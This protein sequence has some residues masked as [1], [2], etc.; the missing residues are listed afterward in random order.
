M[1][2]SVNPEL[3][4]NEVKCVALVNPKLLLVFDVT[5]VVQAGHRHLSL[6]P[7]GFQWNL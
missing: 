6:Q 2:L 5:T 4:Q 1:S 3:V 7:G